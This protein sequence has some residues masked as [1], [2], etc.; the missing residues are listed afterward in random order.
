MGAV[1]SG[2]LTANWI[3]RLNCQIILTRV[4][5]LV[6]AQT[7][8]LYVSGSKQE[9]LT[10]R[11]LSW[12]SLAALLSLQDQMN[13]K[14]SNDYY[15]AYGNIWHLDEILQINTKI[16][17]L[18]LLALIIF[19]NLYYFSFSSQSTFNNNKLHLLIN[20]TTCDDKRIQ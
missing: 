8:Q 9:M 6:R 20:E 17:T 2:L 12:H 14:R 7:Q 11:K 16:L 13:F 15:C 19:V 1:C 18:G 10:N 4:W 3:E 5:L